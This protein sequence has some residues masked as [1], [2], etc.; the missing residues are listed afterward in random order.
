MKKHV[1]MYVVLL[2]L[3][4]PVCLTANPFENELNSLTAQIEQKTDKNTLFNLYKQRGLLYANNGM[5]TEA[6][7]DFYALYDVA[8]TKEQYHEASQIL[9]SFLL[10]LNY[11]EAFQ[12]ALSIANYYVQCFPDDWRTYKWRSDVYLRLGQADNVLA[13]YEQ[14]ERLLSSV[15]A[16]FEADMGIVELYLY[17]TTRQEKYKTSARNRLANA[18]QMLLDS[19]A[20]LSFDLDSNAYKICYC[21]AMSQ[22]VTGSGGSNDALK[23]LCEENPDV[24]DPL[25]LLALSEYFSGDYEACL[26]TTDRLISKTSGQTPDG[27]S[28]HGD[29]MRLESGFYIMFMRINIYQHY[30]DEAKV[31]ESLKIYAREEIDRHLAAINDDVVQSLMP[32]HATTVDEISACLDK[33][34]IS[35]G[36]VSSFWETFRLW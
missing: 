19:G 11:D 14:M 18:N 34:A 30:V 26:Q 35:L 4:S 17:V 3:F 31:S 12:S 7:S 9:I 5:S 15:D 21:N 23:L 13:D 28:L 32:G 33:D 27:K 25:F 6:F 36:L 2:V 24:L 1:L 16:G 10:H 20:S 8:V 29:F 22:F